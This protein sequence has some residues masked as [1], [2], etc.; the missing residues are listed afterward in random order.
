MENKILLIQIFSDAVHTTIPKDTV[1]TLLPFQD[2]YYTVFRARRS[3]PT[4]VTLLWASKQMKS[5]EIIHDE[6]EHNHPGQHAS[7][8]GWRIR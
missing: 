3:I 5:F 7:A 2:N 1:I 8:F 4:R 6:P